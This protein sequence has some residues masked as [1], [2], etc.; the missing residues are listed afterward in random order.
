MIRLV[1]VMRIM[2]VFKVSEVKQTKLNYSIVSIILA[3]QTFRWDP[4]SRIHSAAGLQG[5]WL[6]DGLGWSC[7]SHLRFS[8]LLR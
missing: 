7:S 5:T 8:G 3:S 1:R 2:R 4:V 6:D